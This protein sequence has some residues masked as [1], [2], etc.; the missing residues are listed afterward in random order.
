[1][2]SV[3]IIQISFSYFRNLTA[4]PSSPDLAVSASCILTRKQQKMLPGNWQQ[5]EDRYLPY[6]LLSLEYAAFS[7]D[8]ITWWSELVSTSNLYTL[9]YVWKESK[10]KFILWRIHNIYFFC[11]HGTSA[12]KFYN[13]CQST[14]IDRETKSRNFWNEC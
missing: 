5:G 9:S 8:F 3:I 6:L 4:S 14:V 1:M 7:S 13:Q 11:L 10:G 2:S 12:V